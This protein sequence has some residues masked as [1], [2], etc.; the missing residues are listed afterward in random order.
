MND[1]AQRTDAKRNHSDFTHAAAR[2]RRRSPLNDPAWRL[3]LTA[4]GLGCVGAIVAQVWS[5]G[6]A[7][8]TL[9]A[10]LLLAAGWVQSVRFLLLD[11]ALRRVWLVWLGLGGV[12]LLV[13]GSYPLGRY[14]AIGMAIVFLVMRRYLPYRHLTSGRRARAFGLGLLTL[15]LLIAMP[16]G[17]GYGEAV[18]PVGLAWNVGIFARVALFLFWIFS[19][20][21]L[22]I[23]MRLHFMRLRP[24]LATSAALLGLVPLALVVLLGALILYGALGGSRATRAR[25]IMN[26]W[27]E[28]ADRGVDL[29]GE[30]FTA[31]FVWNEGADRAAE[32]AGAE[33][34][35]TID[36]PHWASRL[37][38]ELRAARAGQ[39]LPTKAVTEPEPESE[40]ESK[41]EADAKRKAR[42]LPGRSGMVTASTA[43]RPSPSSARSEM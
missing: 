40:A 29:T 4:A 16:K 1:T 9:L 22:V 39:A 42:K 41:R 34:T 24:K 18:Y 23:H 6:G 27:A 38:A 3:V 5:G 32:F 28:M 2:S 19:L 7:V 13:A 31:G 21:N 30:P 20:W 33:L 14:L 35:N 36:A 11:S 25:D 37:A 8:A 43:S 15:I 12:A 10:S 26:A 17:T